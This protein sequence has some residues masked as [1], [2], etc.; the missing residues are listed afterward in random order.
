M[1]PLEQIPPKEPRGSLLDER[2]R[3]DRG[4]NSRE[5]EGRVEETRS[6]LCLSYQDDGRISRL[7]TNNRSNARIVEARGEGKG[8]ESEMTDLGVRPRTDL[9]PLL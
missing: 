2:E 8:I 6:A 9:F 4:K 7:G 3:R 1:L 5:E